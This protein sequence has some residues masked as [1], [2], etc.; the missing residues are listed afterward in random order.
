MKN[1]KLIIKKPRTDASQTILKQTD[2][3]GARRSDLSSSRQEDNFENPKSEHR[4]MSH[5]KC[6]VHAEVKGHFYFAVLLATA[7]LP[8]SNSPA[9]LPFSSNSSTAAS[10]R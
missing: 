1:E 8:I 9:Q 4:V 6:M 10:F 7:S 3:T 5:Y 2:K